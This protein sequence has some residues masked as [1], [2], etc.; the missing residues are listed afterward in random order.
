MQLH[1]FGQTQQ[2]LGKNVCIP[3]HYQLLKMETKECQGDPRLERNINMRL[4]TIHFVE[5][6]NYGLLECMVAHPVFISAQYVIVR[7]LQIQSCFVTIVKVLSLLYC[8]NHALY[9]L[10]QWSF[11]KISWPIILLWK[12]RF[13]IQYL[14]NIKPQNDIVTHLLWEA[15]I[16]TNLSVKTPKKMYA[17]IH[18][19][20]SSFR[21]SIIL[22][23][24]NE[25]FNN[26][27]GWLLCTRMNK[28]WHRNKH[29]NTKHFQIVNKTSFQ[30]I[31][32]S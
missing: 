11:S 23:G 19:E 9:L 21:L 7:L 1:L 30:K 20:N 4:G 8:H 28:I 29:L 32:I 25:I 12:S 22:R 2:M 10:K 24:G 31:N 5:F 3:M 17:L 16:M 26:T 18:V 13:C 27:L 6:L 14:N 15:L